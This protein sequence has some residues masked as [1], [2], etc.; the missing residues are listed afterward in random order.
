MTGKRVLAGVLAAA[1]LAV[2]P[3]FTAFAEEGQET[4]AADGAEAPQPEKTPEEL[5][6]EEEARKNA[7]YETIPDSNQLPGWPEGPKVHAASAIVMDMESGAVLYAKAA[8]EQ[9][10][11]ASI[12][13]LLTTL[14]ALETGE[15]DDT[16]TFTED[17]ISFLEPGDASIGMLAGEQLSLNDALHAVLLASANEVSYA[18]AENMGIKMGGTYQTFIDRMNERSAELGCTGSHWVNANGLH[19]DQH[20]TTAH[21]MA[22]I[23]SAVYQ[24]EPFHH[25]MG[26]LEYTIAP[27]SLK[28]E[29]RTCWQNHRMLWP[30]NEFYYEFCRGGKTGYTDQSGT[31]LVTMA[32]NGQMRLAAVVMADYGIQAYEDTRAM[33]DYAFGN[34][35]K[36]TIADKETSGDIETFQDEGAYVVLPA[37][38]DFTQL[39]CQISAAEAPAGTG[40]VSFDRWIE[41]LTAPP[42]PP[43]ETPADGADGTQP[44]GTQPGAE[45]TPEAQAG[46]TPVSVEGTQPEADETAGEGS[47]GSDG[48]SGTFGNAAGEDDA[49]FGSE[50]AGTIVYTY[51]GQEAGHAAVVLNQSYFGQ[52]S[53]MEWTPADG[54]KRKSGESSPAKL[55]RFSTRQMIVAGGAAVLLIVV[56][57]IGL[58]RRKR[59][60]ERKRRNR[61]NEK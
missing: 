21:D 39:E 27:T 59:A 33:L 23:A 42:A 29:A 18:V 38:V 46:T 58:N 16:V 3:G 53:E 19:D 15:P 52:E 45:G 9:H 25:F 40:A 12:T 36:V 54:S 44:D 24:Y 8:E 35:T 6:A 14:V 60:Q 22:R 57:C 34:F 5:A 10:F 41:V 51:A 37:G 17:S 31:T 13:K 7:I 30:E 61:K 4:P 48:D 11:P 50:R 1:L 55:G 43:A 20:Y 26:A 49:L 2:S 56:L 32:D 28:N 47:S